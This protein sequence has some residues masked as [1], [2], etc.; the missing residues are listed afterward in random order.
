MFD[1]IRSA[2]PQQNLDLP[3]K[4]EALEMVLGRWQSHIATY[5]VPK[6][7]EVWVD[8]V[9]NNSRYK[10]I[11]SI[12]F[13]SLDIYL[14]PD[15][16][17]FQH[18]DMISG[19]RKQKGNPCT[20]ASAVF[21]SKICHKEPFDIDTCVIEGERIHGE[22]A[23]NAEAYQVINLP[24]FNAFL[25][26]CADPMSGYIGKEAFQELIRQLT[27][28]AQPSGF[29]ITAQDKTYALA[30]AN[31]LFYL[32]DSHGNDLANPAA[33]YCMAFEKPLDT[34]DFLIRLIPKIQTCVSGLS[35]EISKAIDADY[36]ING[37]VA[38][39][40]SGEAPAAA[41]SLRAIEVEYDTGFGNTLCLATA[42]DWS[43]EHPMECEGSS[44]WKTKTG[45]EMTPGIE[46]KFILKGQ[47]DPKWEEGENR[48]FIEE[49][50]LQTPPTFPA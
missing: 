18:L 35:E 40:V 37:F 10:D 7:L 33:A 8:T 36:A 20:E 17:T 30:H 1:V 39:F 46:F 22:K 32:F 9:S 47:G 27:S 13:A 28:L 5:G 16:V 6:N 14:S 38:I 44:I 4:D 21:L 12:V 24:P 25:S 2:L 3:S 48:L 43:V 19:T 29:F 23:R 11:Q 42:P 15:L 45:F 31:D 34:I 41:M 49:G 26:E 50:T